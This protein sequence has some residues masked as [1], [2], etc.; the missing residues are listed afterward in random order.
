[1]RSPIGTSGPLTLAD[2]FAAV[3]EVTSDEREATAVVLDMLLRGSIRLQGPAGA[4]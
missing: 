1:M 2:V 4:H 3:M